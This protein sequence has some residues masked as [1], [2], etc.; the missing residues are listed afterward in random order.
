ALRRSAHPLAGPLTVTGL[1]SRVRRLLV[2]AGRRKRIAVLSVPA[3]PFGG[4]PVQT[5]RPGAAV[6]TA[7]STGDIGLGAVGT[8]TYRDGANVWAFVHP[9]VD[10]RPRALFLQDAFVF[11]VLPRL[12]AYRLFVLGKRA[13]A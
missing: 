13:C 7:Y 12:R 10:V 6:T 2:R 11:G 4:Y 3:G 9:L 8:V 5:L 1:S